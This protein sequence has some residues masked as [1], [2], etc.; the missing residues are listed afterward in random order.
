MKLPG[1]KRDAE[2]SGGAVDLVSTAGAEL[3]AAA[4]P[5]GTAPKGR[6]TPKRDAKR[7]GPVAPAPMTS[8]EARARRKALAGPKL[9]KEERRRKK[10]QLRERRSDHHQRMLAGDETALLER[11]RG[12]VRRYIRDVVDTRR[13]LLGLF[14][15][16]AL[17]V[18]FVA[19][20]DPRLQ[21]YITPAM[22]LLM[23]L[24]A[25]D[26]VVLTR[27][28]GR[29]V[30]AKFPN[31]TESRLRLGLYGAQ[32]ASTVRRMRTP[33]PQVQRGDKLD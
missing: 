5:G 8:A 31:N 19:M 6:P 25:V 23:V 10:E 24:M 2:R 32:R 3:D 29:L 16:T 11:D 15:P 4:A 26:A 22:M 27:K 1:R 9:S 21:F 17:A 13:N 30:D 33:R 14:M 12:P 18:V 28:I 7:R 20:A